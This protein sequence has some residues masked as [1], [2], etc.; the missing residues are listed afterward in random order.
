MPRA[1]G[2]QTSRQAEKLLYFVM[3]RQH[4][5]PCPVLEAAYQRLADAASAA[6]GWD[7]RTVILDWLES[8]LAS[9]SRDGKDVGGSGIQLMKAAVALSQALTQ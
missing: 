9:L 3:L 5:T 6:A 4:E 8:E 1:A 7:L 2:Q